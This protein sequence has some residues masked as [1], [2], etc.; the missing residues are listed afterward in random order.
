MKKK[1]LILSAA[2]GGG[3][4]TAARALFETCKITNPEFNPVWFDSFDYC[5]RIYARAYHGAYQLMA[6]HLPHLYGWCYD[7]QD[8]QKRKPNSGVIVRFCDKFL[9]RRLKHRIQEEAPTHILCTHFQPAAAVEALRKSG[10]LAA[11]VG[12]VGCDFYL[13]SFWEAPGVDFFFVATDEIKEIFIE[14]GFD[15]AMVHVTGIPVAPEFSR[16]LDRAQARR[17]LGLH[18]DSPVVLTMASGWQKVGSEDIVSALIESGIK[19]QILAVTGKSESALKR[20]KALETP[21]GVEMH[22]FGFV[23]NVAEMMSASDLLVAKAGGLTMVEALAKSLPVIAMNPVPG[24][25]VHNAHYLMEQG[26]GMMASNK[27][28]LKIKLREVLGEGGRAGLMRERARAIGR[29]R[30]AFDIVELVA[31]M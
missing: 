7:A 5:P 4:K 23:N 10:K 17:N 31:D 30:A 28:S 15:P 27:A 14:R 21:P 19:M 20:I 13:H 26:A 6:D 16:E 9:L 12:V 8:R 3:H 29:P 24:Q 2:V 22:A 11:K 25:E 1:L 18:D